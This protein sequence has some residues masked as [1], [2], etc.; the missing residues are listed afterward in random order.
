[1]LTQTQNGLL[2]AQRALERV[3]LPVAYGAEQDGIGFLR[4]CERRI[5]Q[6]VALGFVTRATDRRLFKL[7]FLF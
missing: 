2:R 1:M 7:E 4:Q 6:R 5:G 3:V